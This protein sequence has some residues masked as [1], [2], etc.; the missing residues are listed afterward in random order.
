VIVSEFDRWVG[1]NNIP[2]RFRYGKAWWDYVELVRRFAHKFEIHD[3]RVIGHYVV[4]TPPP[5]ERLPMPAVSLARSGV[6]IALKWDFGATCSWP[7][8]WTISV[9]RPSPYLGPTFAL[10]DPTQDLRAAPVAGLSPDFIF[11]PYCENP[12]EF[13]CAIDDEWDVAA[14]LRLVFHEP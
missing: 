4:Q 5:E 6:L 8:E 1:A 13:S 11:P 10:F 14:L 3:V 2:E 12:G 7:R 9:R